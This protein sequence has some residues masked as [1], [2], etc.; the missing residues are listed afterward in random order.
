[1][2]SVIHVPVQVKKSLLIRR[3]V[4]HYLS[5]P[6]AGTLPQLPITIIYKFGDI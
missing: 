2:A 1:M 6:R 5:K 3:L 4:N